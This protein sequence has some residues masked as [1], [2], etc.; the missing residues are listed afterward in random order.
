MQDAPRLRGVGWSGLL[1]DGGRGR[2]GERER[3]GEKER[4][5][6]RRV[7]GLGGVAGEK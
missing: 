4:E 1:V 3:K 2:E 6:G 7:T 5:R